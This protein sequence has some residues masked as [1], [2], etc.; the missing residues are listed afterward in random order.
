MFGYAA[1]RVITRNTSR[2]DSALINESESDGWYIDAP[3]AWFRWEMLKDSHQV[4]K[5]VTL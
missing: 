3:R 2:R 4:R 1:R 5:K